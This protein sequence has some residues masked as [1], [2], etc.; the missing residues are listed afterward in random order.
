[1]PFYGLAVLCLDH[2]QVQDILPRIQRRHVTYGVSPQADYSARGIHFRGLETS[3]NAY[4]RGVRSA[5]SRCVCRARTTCST[6]SRRS[7]S[8]TSSRSRSTSPSR[9]S[10]PSTASRGASRSSGVR[11]A[12]CL[13]DDYGHHPAEIRATL[14]AA[15]RAFPSEDH[16]VVVAFQP[17]RYSRT[18]DLFDDFSRAFNQADVLLVTDI[19][20][21]GEAPIEG[22]TPSASCSRS[23]STATTTRATSTTRRS[24]PTLESSCAEVTS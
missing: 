3:F 23:A 10:R 20:A 2:P 21:A 13:V 7:P 6:A 17:H 14:D 8:P 24:S 4:R 18:R 5:A 1:V 12:G 15:R 11:R 19:Y 16:R 9:R 22:A